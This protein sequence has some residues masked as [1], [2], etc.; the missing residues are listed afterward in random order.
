MVVDTPSVTQIL[1]FQSPQDSIGSQTTILEGESNQDS[2]SWEDTQESQ[3]PKED[4]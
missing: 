2:V 3:D 1:D 4:R